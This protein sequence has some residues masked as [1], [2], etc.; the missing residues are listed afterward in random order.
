MDESGIEQDH[1]PPLIH[2]RCA[3]V[4]A[5]DF[6]WELV[7]GGLLGGVIP[8]QLVVAFGEVDV[9][10]VEDGGPLKRSSL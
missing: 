7:F 2:D 8:G 5:T 4:G 3:T 6:A 10:F 1:V 9:F